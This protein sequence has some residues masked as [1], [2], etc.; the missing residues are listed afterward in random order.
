MVNNKRLRE[1]FNDGVLSFG[2]RVT[3]RSETGKKIGE[4]FME[5][6]R[7]FYREMSH[8]EADYRL[9][10]ALGSSLDIKVKTMYPPSFR[11]VDCNR[12]VI[13]IGEDEYETIRVD[14]DETK[15]YLYFYLQK[16]G[17]SNE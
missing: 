16:V 15:S 14:T 13:H 9:V 17:N 5:E 11:T 2:H 1:T 7:L 8:R 3:Q 6:G 12:L 4:T 10:D